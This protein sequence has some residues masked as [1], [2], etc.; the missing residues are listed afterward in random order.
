M[1]HVWFDLVILRSFSDSPLT[2]SEFPRRGMG[3]T[4]ICETLSVGAGFGIVTSM[5]S[6]LVNS[7]PVFFSR[8]WRYVKVKEDI[9][10]KQLIFPIT[11]KHT[12]FVH[13]HILP[14]LRGTGS[15]WPQNLPWMNSRPEMTK[16]QR[17]QTEFLY[18]FSTP[19]KH[20]EKKHGPHDVRLICWWYDNVMYVYVCYIPFI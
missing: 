12:F 20:A 2:P 5:K 1:K 16:V 7:T 14:A 11:S 8:V 10:K 13:L 17:W 15:F 4:N 6:D 19:K 9:Q 18:S 3:R